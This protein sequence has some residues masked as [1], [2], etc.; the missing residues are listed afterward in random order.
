MKSRFL[1]KGFFYGIS[2]I[3]CMIYGHLSHLEIIS[4][5]LGVGRH[6]ITLKYLVPSKIVINSRPVILKSIFSPKSIIIFPT[7]FLND[8]IY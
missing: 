2:G 6:L 1:K 5:K 4:E 8:V 3:I 7:L